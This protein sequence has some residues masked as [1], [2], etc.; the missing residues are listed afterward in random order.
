MRDFL[1]VLPEI[2]P[3]ILILGI[4][5]ILI[6]IFLVILGTA[7]S[8]EIVEAESGGLLMIGPMPIIFHGKLGPLVGL[9]ILILITIIFLLPLLYL[10]MLTA[11]G[12]REREKASD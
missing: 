8:R 1:K 11:R 2:L 10:F 12:P 9:L 3:I 5:L 6:G 7:P 4:T